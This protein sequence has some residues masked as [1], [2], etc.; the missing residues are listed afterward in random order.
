[1]PSG[2]ARNA[3]ALPASSGASRCPGLRGVGASR[4]LSGLRGVRPRG[5]AVSDRVLILFLKGGFAVSAGF[6]VSDQAERKHRHRVPGGSAGSGGSAG[7]GPVS[8]FRVASL[9]LTPNEWIKA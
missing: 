5:F 6:E 3:P 9:I 4:C 2:A 8:G 7:P 1:V